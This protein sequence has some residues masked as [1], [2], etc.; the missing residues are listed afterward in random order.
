MLRIMPESYRPSGGVGLHDD[1]RSVIGSKMTGPAFVLHDIPYF[2]NPFS[3]HEIW[4]WCGAELF[5]NMRI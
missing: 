1:I 5:L 3:K 2:E 4:D